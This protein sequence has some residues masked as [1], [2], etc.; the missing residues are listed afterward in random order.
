M[1]Q[2]RALVQKERC[3]DCNAR[4]TTFLLHVT[5][6]PISLVCTNCAGVHREFD[7]H[8]V[9]SIGLANH[10]EEEVKAVAKAGGNEQARK[11]LMAKWT[12]EE[13]PRMRQPPARALTPSASVRRHPPRLFHAPARRAANLTRDRAWRPRPMPSPVT[14][15]CPRR[16]T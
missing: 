4:A 7:G 14:A 13:Y 11:V 5:S 8:R 1:K 12:Q 16:G 3:A 10:T 6:L 2:L 9:K 15:Q